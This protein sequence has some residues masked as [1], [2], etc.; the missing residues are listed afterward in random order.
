LFPVA[1]GGRAVL[2][3]DIHP[4]TA[5]I[6]LDI[7]IDKNHKLWFIEANYCDERYFYRE[8]SDFDMWQ[9]SY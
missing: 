2:F 4:S 5:D 3:K 1:Q 7:A 8:S 9:A 6:G